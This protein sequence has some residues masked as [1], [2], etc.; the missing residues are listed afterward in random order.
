MYN[1]LYKGRRFKIHCQDINRHIALSN[2]D[3]ERYIAH[4]IRQSDS[5][6]NGEKSSYQ[7]EMQK[8]KQCLDEVNTI[9]Q[10]MYAD[11]VFKRISEERYASM[12]VNLEKEEKQLKERYDKIQTK[13]S[14]YT[15]HSKS[16]QDFA[17]LIEQY[18]LIT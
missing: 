2:E 10:N 6:L 13:R 16:A 15:Q 17:D 14:Q 9:L 18:S 7:K 5:E 8:I 3:K 1:P 4:L 11:K 12:S